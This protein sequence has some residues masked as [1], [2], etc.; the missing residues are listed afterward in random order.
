MW[1][2]KKSGCD[3]VIKK[4]A[5]HCCRRPDGLRATQEPTWLREQGR[6]FQNST[7]F[8]FLL[9][10]RVTKRGLPNW[11]WKFKS[12]S[13]QHKSQH[14]WGNEVDIFRKS[15]FFTF[16]KDKEQ[17]GG[18]QNQNIYVNLL[19]NHWMEFGWNG[20]IKRSWVFFR[21]IPIFAPS[22]SD[23][24]TEGKNI[25]VSFID[26]PLNSFVLQGKKIL[27]VEFQAAKW[28]TWGDESWTGNQDVGGAKEGEF[29][30]CLLLFILKIV[31]S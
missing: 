4:T 1:C 7:Y 27:K 31:A 15:G 25:Y 30:V 8:L 24:T 16:Y 13:K 26:R 5:Q 9:Q 14:G 28:E 20:C 18:D 11:R 22:V 12:Y 6:R 19:Q 3:G 10:S 23:N 21:Q 2:E 17:N 29:Q